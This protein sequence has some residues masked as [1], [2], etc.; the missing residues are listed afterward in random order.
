MSE[1]VQVAVLEQGEGDADNIVSKDVR[2]VKVQRGASC[3]LLSILCNH[4]PQC[5]KDH[6]LIKWFTDCEAAAKI[7]EFGNQVCIKWPEGF[8]IFVSDWEF[9]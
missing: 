6:T 7:V 4:L 3:P 2:E 1:E 5:W 8:F 9:I